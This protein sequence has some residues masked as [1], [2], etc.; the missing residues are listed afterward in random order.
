MEKEDA[1]GDGIILSAA[2]MF[3]NR[4]IQVL[5][6]NNPTVQNIINTVIHNESSFSSKP[7]F[8]GYVECPIN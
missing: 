3:Y 2:S 8:L 7:M 4:P 1:W 6:S 5:S